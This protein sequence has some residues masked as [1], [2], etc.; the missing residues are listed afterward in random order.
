MPGKLFVFFLILLCFGEILKLTE[1]VGNETSDPNSL[2]S[3]GSPGLA[4]LSSSAIWKSDTE[5]DAGEPVLIFA[6]NSES[7]SVGFP[8]WAAYC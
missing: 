1:A 6:Q 2:S 8:L 5:G 4:T 7:H 3:S